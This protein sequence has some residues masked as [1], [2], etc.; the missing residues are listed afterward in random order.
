MGIVIDVEQYGEFVT[1]VMV[2]EPEYVVSNCTPLVV[3]VV[4]GGVSGHMI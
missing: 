1:V 3:R 4:R 2:M